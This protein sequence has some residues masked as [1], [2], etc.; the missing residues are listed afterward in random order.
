MKDPSYKLQKAPRYL[1]LTI[2]YSI[3]EIPRDIEQLSRLLGY[4]EM[5]SDV[6]EYAKARFAEQLK[7]QKIE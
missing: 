2:Y 1:N 5:L 7:Q 4:R 6:V 3:L